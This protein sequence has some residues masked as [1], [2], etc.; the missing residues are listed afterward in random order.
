MPYAL[1]EINYVGICHSNIHHG[2]GDWGPAH[3]PAVP[4][5]EI[6]GAVTA[7]TSS[8]VSLTASPWTKP[9]RCC[10]EHQ[11]PLATAPVGRRPQHRGGGRVDRATQQVARDEGRVGPAT[12]IVRH[13]RTSATG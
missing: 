9:P 4:G 2:H 12:H 5:H 11:R 13:G 3:Y 8:S 1:I 10:R 7:R 6:A